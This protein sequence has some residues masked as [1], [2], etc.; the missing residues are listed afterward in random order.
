MVIRGHCIASGQLSGKSPV[1]S[2]IMERAGPSVQESI[3][4]YDDVNVYLDVIE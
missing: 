2:S 3:T 1:L 4:R